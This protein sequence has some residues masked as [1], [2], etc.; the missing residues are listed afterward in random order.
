[1]KICK[2]CKKKLGFFDKIFYSG[3]CAS[4]KSIETKKQKEEREKFE[5]DNL[6]ENAGTE[7]WK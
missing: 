4:C 7:R 6:M 3:F 5:R 1:M 2:K